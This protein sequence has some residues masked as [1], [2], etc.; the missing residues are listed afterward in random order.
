MS[1]PQTANNRV[2][3][4]QTDDMVRRTRAEGSLV[5]LLCFRLSLVC[6]RN[7]RLGI[8]TFGP[9]GQVLPEF[10]VP[11]IKE[12]GACVCEYVEEDG[13]QETQRHFEEPRKMLTWR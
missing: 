8:E 2:W 9:N 10:S 12:L 5:L 11:L 7:D 1:H 4:F 13:R 3:L 6:A